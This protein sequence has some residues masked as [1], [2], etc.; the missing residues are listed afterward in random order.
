MWTVPDIKVALNVA[1]LP[2]ALVQAQLDFVNDEVVRQNGPH[3]EGQVIH[4]VWRLWRDRESVLQMP[5]RATVS[6]MTV[7]ELDLDLDYVVIDDNG[8]IRRRYP[9]YP[10]WYNVTAIGNMPSAD[11]RRRA[12]VLNLVRIQIA[13]GAVGQESILG[14]STSY[15]DQQK[16]Y[17]EQMMMLSN[18]QIEFA[19]WPDE[20]TFPTAPP[21]T[22]SNVFV[23]V[24]PS[25]AVQQA[26][27]AGAGVSFGSGRFSIPSY[28][29]QQYIWYAQQTD[30]PDP[31]WI[32]F[33]DLFNEI[34]L[35]NKRTVGDYD[36]WISQRALDVSGDTLV[37]RR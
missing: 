21:P 27:L 16:M 8:M 1:H 35:Y 9:R 7:G 17:N 13:R 36:V 31:T 24:S 5:Y 23:G 20:I 22:V 29:G 12:I 4:C 19:R 18:H 10:F 30:Q 25:A 15:A 3:P 6:R 32:A 34:T 14:V 11:A 26:Q 2:D 28:S 37:V 33:G